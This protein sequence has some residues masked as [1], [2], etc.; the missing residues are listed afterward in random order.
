MDRRRLMGLGALLGSAV[1][2]DMSAAGLARA[3]AQDA[4]SKTGEPVRTMLFPDDALFWGS[5]FRVMGQTE[6]GSALVGE[7]IATAHKVQGHDYDSWYEA[8]NWLADKVAAEADRSMAKKHLVSARDGY[9]RASNYYRESEFFLHAN[10]RDPRI[11]RAYKR[12]VE[13]YTK[14]GAL[15][16][17]AIVPVEIP[18]EGTTLPG[19]MSFPKP[20]RKGRKTIIM[21]TGFD[22]S[23]EE[24][25]GQGFAA[26]WERDY[27]VLVFD[28]P[29]Q[30][31]PIHRQGLPFRH[32]WEK[33]I[34]PVVDFVLEQPG[35]D[36]ER[37]SLMGISLGGY[38]APR[39]A[40]F[41]KRIK[42]LICNDGV[43]DFSGRFTEIA[44]PAEREAFIAGIRAE[45]SP[46]ADARIQAA[47]E[48]SHQMRWFV[49]HGMY[50]FGARTPRE[51]VRKTLDYN[52]RN[53]LAER[54]TCPT[55]VC[56]P[57]ADA[58]QRGRAN[59]SEVLYSH[60]TCPKVLIDFSGEEGAGEHVQAGAGRLA[61]GRIYDWLDEV[62]A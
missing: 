6:Y 9:L 3:A 31:G 7:V 61:F 32:D 2:L 59:P 51:F 14:A 50:A 16:R 40:V 18:Y 17:P 30:F 15:F 41:E 8:W 12:T 58:F 60:L 24:L 1:G 47:M 55:A 23:A 21:H 13:C 38:L 33:V 4:R 42:A 45:H 39:A 29:G 19:Y 48:A 27:N 36:P 37:L 34:G 5:A 44:P 53:G 35:V 20:A 28:G 54:I 11:A 10:P 26:A 62:L 46:E 22:G 57:T 56:N 25:H 49:T 52:L 43:Y